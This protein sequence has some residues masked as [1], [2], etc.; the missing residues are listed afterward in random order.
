MRL[1]AV[2][3]GSL[4]R[5]RAATLFSFAAIVLGVALGMAVEAVHRA[6]LTEFGRGLRTLSGSADLQVTGP[7]AGFDE[8]L[9]PLLAARPEVAGASPVLEVETQVVGRSLMLEVLG[10]DV[11]RVARVTPALLARPAA[12]A[13]ATGPGPDRDRAQPAAREP[14][15]GGLDVLA[16]DAVFLSAGAREVLGLAPGGR[17]RLHAGGASLDLRL[18]GDLPGAAENRRLAVMDIAAVQAAFERVGRLSRIDLRLAPGVSPAAARAAL[19]P[20]LPAGVQLEDPEAA[21]DQAVNLSRAY[22]VNLTM[23]AAIALLT[24]GFLVFSA[25]ALAV[26]RRRTE[27]AFLRAIGLPRRSLFAWLL[28]EGAAVGLLGGVAGVALGHAL[29]WGLLHA[30][31][32][33]LGA[34]FFAGLVPRLSFDPGSAAVYCLLGLAAGVAGAW[35]PAREAAAV[36]PAQA[37]KAGDEAVLAGGGG[38]SWLGFAVLG[39]SL[40]AALLPPIDNLPLGGYLAAVCLLAGGVLLLPRIAALVARVLPDGGPV[41]ARLAAAR[42]SAAPGHAVVA[43][44]GVL[45]SVALAVAMAIMVA[46]FRASVDEW[47]GAVLPAD[48]YVRAGH[49]HMGSVLDEPLQARIGAVP[50]VARVRFTRHDSLRLAPGRPPVAVIARPTPAADPDLP[51]VATAPALPPSTGELPPALWI[52]EAV[53]DL[54][55]WRP[56]Q[57]VEVPLGGRPVSMRVAGV[58]RDYARQT[59]T[60]VIDLGDY[61][62][63]TG[64]AVVN[65]A[66]I[67]LTPGADPWRVAEAL[68]AT[69][70]PGALEV[71]SPGE[72]RARSLEVFDRTFA[73]TYLLEAAAVGIGLAGVAASFAALAAARRREFGMLRH[74]GVTRRQIGWMLALEG[75]LAAAVGVV[76]GFLAGGAIGLVL[77]EVVNRQSFHWSMDLHAP[78]SSLAVFAL[79]LIALA[80]LAA[81]AAGRQAMRREAVL[82]VREDW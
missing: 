32:G 31:G 28:A 2:F 18:A 13:D 25:Q 39:A 66:A 81:V 3:L 4:A 56:G 8:G 44:A 16:P 52:S 27:F 22:R 12:G 65:D 17:L 76:G 7:R 73:V 54:Y 63:L 23:L 9:Y 6:A 69:G 61:R 62:R 43:A 1:A 48:L 24:G 67:W 70:E 37:L 11:F 60:V 78:W 71:A 49:M 59:G 77:I 53:A 82:A 38:R 41:P 19:G 34:G 68:A 42:L 47:L 30:L 21:E 10:V 58:W 20:L 72:I 14:G 57:R 36:A 26:V 51:L 40:P 50:G 80:A 46:S 45:A 29:A 55:D 33:D 75:A 15:R 64:E 35:L 74:L 5:R 79:S